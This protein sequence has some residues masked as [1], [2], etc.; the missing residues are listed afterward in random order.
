VAA[1]TPAPDSSGPAPEEIAVEF[2]I[3]VQP[4]GS[5][6]V[7]AVTAADGAAVAGTVERSGGNTFVFMP[8]A[9][10]APGVYT[11]TAFNVT[12]T[13][14]MVRPFVWSFTVEE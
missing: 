2:T 10:L 4:A 12:Q 3:S 13:T 1:V 9:L 6:P 5:E 7:I 8:S 14:A 11:A